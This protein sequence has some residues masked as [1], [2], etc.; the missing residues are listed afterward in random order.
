[1]RC[2]QSRA[3][4]SRSSSA[5]ACSLA[6]VRW[7]SRYTSR[8]SSGTVETA[9]MASTAKPVGWEP[10]VPEL[11]GLMGLLGVGAG[12][13]GA[14]R[15][16]AE[17]FSATLWTGHGWGGRAEPDV[18]ARRE[19]ATGSLFQ[20]DDMVPISMAERTGR[21]QPLAVGVPEPVLRHERALIS[22]HSGCGPC[23]RRRGRPEWSAGRIA[24]PHPPRHR[25]PPC[26]A[27]TLRT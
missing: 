23:L 7:S 5:S 15:G 10:A 27:R 22:A 19:F 13:R 20:F 2:S 21:G 14:E 24:L 26:G 6:H 17:G 1:M 4:R 12:I 11:T 16:V 18:P 25:S 8:S 3:S 9:I